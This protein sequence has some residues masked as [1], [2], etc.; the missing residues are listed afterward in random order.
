MGPQS[1]GGGGGTEKV[2]ATNPRPRVSWTSCRESTRKK[3]PIFV[4]SSQSPKWNAF[5]FK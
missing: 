4:D 5:F 2:L 3:R 1:G